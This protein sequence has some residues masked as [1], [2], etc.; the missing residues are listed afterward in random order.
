MDAQIFNDSVLKFIMINDK[1]EL[2]VSSQLPGYDTPFSFVVND[3]FVLKTRLTNH[4]QKG[5][6]CT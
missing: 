6:N 4:F 5:T 2:P 1:L 3:A